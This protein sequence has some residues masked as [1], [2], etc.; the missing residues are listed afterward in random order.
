MALADHQRLV[1]AMVRDDA[2][3]T[4]AG[5]LADAIAAAVARYS[6][7]RP[8]QVVED[9]V[10]GA[11]GLLPIPGF[12]G[13]TWKIAA[14]ESPIGREPLETVER[15]G[16]RVLRTPTGWQVAAP[17][18]TG[19]AARVSLYRPHTLTGADGVP[20]D[21]DTIP[22]ADREAVASWA[23]AA[24]LDELAARAAG[25]T[26]STIAADGVDYGG[27][28]DRYR[29]CAARRRELYRELMGR[30]PRP[31]PRPAGTVVSL[32]RGRLSTGGPRLTHRSGR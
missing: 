23:A 1:A 7:D 10:V 25:V 6:V 2:N 4:D 5:D 21:T 18:R 24:L 32:G 27:A 17:L 16:W 26:D 11:G 28:A 14:V 29:R 22:P 31:V 13:Q 9:V 30:P 8:R 15:G 20:A 19:A 12:D 3:V